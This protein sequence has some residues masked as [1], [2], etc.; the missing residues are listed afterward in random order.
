MIQINIHAPLL[1]ERV[2]CAAVLSGMRLCAVA[3]F[4]YSHASID[5]P[6]AVLLAVPK[7]TVE[8]LQYFKFKNTSR[9]PCVHTYQLEES[10]HK[11]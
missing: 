1:Y 5:T 2:H 4:I 3:I 9:V 11:V 8:H 7:T 6:P 10:T